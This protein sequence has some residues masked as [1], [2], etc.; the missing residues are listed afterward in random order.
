MNVMEVTSSVGRDDAAR[1]RS[2]T[3]LPRATSS[4]GDA[5]KVS[6]RLRVRLLTVKRKQAVDDCFRFALLASGAVGTLGALHK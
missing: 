4:N 1:R 2:R 6:A 5:T 3:T